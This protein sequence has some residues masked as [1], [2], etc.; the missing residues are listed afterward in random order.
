MDLRVL[1]LHRKKVDVL[2]RKRARL[3]RLTMERSP[4][5][6]ASFMPRKAEAGRCFGV[7][8]FCLGPRGKPASLCA[9]RRGRVLAEAGLG[10]AQVD[11]GHG[12]LGEGESGNREGAQRDREA[13]G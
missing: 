8:S 6:A 2:M 3:E 11:E 9:Q 1:S 7:L 12:C 13:S 10:L 4:M 5:V